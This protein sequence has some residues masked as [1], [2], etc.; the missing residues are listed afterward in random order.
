MADDQPQHPT[1]K[2]L[3]T[4]SNDAE[5]SMVLGDL[6]AAG[7]R[8]MQ[9]SST[10]GGGVWGAPPPC[11]IY[12]DEQ[13]FDRAREIRDTE[14]MSER[15]LVQAEEEAATQQTEPKGKNA[16]GEPYEPVEIPVPKRSAFDRLLHRAENTPPAKRH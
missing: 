12:V 14:A 6:K 9:Q 11:D 10:R 2:I 16:E 7:I 13:D 8:A 15:E 3:T 4:V 5:A 1:L